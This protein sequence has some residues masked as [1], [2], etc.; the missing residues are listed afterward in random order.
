ML[1]SSCSSTVP[2]A[3]RVVIPTCVYQLEDLIMNREVKELHPITC[4]NIAEALSAA[5]LE[6]PA[7]A[8]ALLEPVRL[9]LSIAKVSSEHPAQKVHAEAK[10]NQDGVMST[11]AQ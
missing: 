2:R 9:S 6:T 5:L 4:R 3:L 10:G 1:I 8:V 11:K 7:K